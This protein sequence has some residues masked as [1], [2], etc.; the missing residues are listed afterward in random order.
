M[1]QKVM[2]MSSSS[3]ACTAPL[4]T[5]TSAGRSSG[6]VRAAVDSSSQALNSGVE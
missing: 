1:M 4:L 5:G 3:P 2:A 6:S